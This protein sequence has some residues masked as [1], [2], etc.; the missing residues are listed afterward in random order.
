MRIG[1][2]ALLILLCSLTGDG[3]LAAV[4]NVPT[5]N[6]DIRPIFADNC[7]ACHGPDKN[8]R[9]A[10]LRLDNAE[11]AYAEKD[12]SFPIVPGKANESEVIRHITST[13][14]DELMPPPKTGKKLTAQ[15]IDTI[16]RWIEGGAKYERH[17]AYIMPQRPPLPAVNQANWPSNPIDNF[18]LARLE[19]EGLSPSPDADRRT[20]IRRLSFDLAGLPPK[21]ELV[22]SFMK[23]SDSQAYAKLVRSLLESP[24]FGERMAVTWLDLVR[25]ADTVGYHGDNP[26]SVWPYRD[27]VINAFNSN[28]A[29]DQFTR[30]QIAGDLIPNATVEQRVASTF[31]R[32]NRMSTEGGIQDKEYLAKYASDRV[33]TL[34][35]VWMGATMGC[36]EC[37]DHKFDP[38]STKDFYQMEAFFADLKEKGFYPDGYGKGDWGVKMSVP[39]AAQAKR[40]N[41]IDA[42]ISTVTNRIANF[43]EESLAKNRIE[44]EKQIDWLAKGDRLNWK[45]VVPAKASSSEGST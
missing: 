2:T 26:V 33:R 42:Q 25:Y 9:K 11:G 6:R 1:R 19:K 5:F 8:T 35:A 27:Y 17:W 45:E 30:E 15:Q 20:Q 18:I 13:D 39:S 44:W 28:L 21:P 40:L 38:F 4:T 37:H 3:V 14:P 32:L 24:H 43:P 34:S 41:E 36:A 12:G 7:Y 29:F 22:E 23:S 31:N 16:R 10:K